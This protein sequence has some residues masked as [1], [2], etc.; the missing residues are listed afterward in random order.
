MNLE[1]SNRQLGH[2]IASSLCSTEV[3]YDLKNLEICCY[4]CNINKSG[5]TLQFRLNLIRDHGEAYVD[6]LWTRNAGT[7]GK[8]Y[9]ADWFRD[10]I[11]EYEKLL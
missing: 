2:Y 9:T 11:S 6:E 3:R 10:K 8:V 7:K 1:G 5:N 4:N